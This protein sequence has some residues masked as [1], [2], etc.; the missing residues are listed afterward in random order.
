MVASGEDR[1]SNMDYLMRLNIY[2]SGDPLRYEKQMIDDWFKSDF[3]RV[4]AR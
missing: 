1:L 3:R 4:A 2:S